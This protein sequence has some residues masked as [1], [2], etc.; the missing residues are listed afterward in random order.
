M[1]NSQDLEGRMPVSWWVGVVL[2]G[3]AM[4]NLGMLMGALV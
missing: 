4:F 3:A 2:F 1:G